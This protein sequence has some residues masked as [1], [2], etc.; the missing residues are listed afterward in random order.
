MDKELKAMGTKFEIKV[1]RELVRV[2]LSVLPAD[3]E[4]AANLIFEAVLEPALNENQIENEREFMQ[5]YQLKFQ[6][7][8]YAQTVELLWGT[9]FRDHMLSYPVYGNR[10]S[11]V[12]IK[13]NSMERHMKRCYLA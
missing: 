4:R 9:T 1:E 10:D 6:Q 13:K 5:N 7:D 3:L 8:Q 11:L 12:N 2:S